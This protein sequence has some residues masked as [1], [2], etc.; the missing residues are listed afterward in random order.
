MLYG[1]AL[2][3]AVSAGAL[4]AWG[5]AARP[6]EVTVSAAASLTDVLREAAR[7]YELRT[8]DRVVLNL[9]ASNTLARQ[10]A[11]GGRVDVFI[12][13]DAAQMDLVA[14]HLVPGSRIDLLSN[15]LAIAVPDDR[16]IR[17]TSARDLARRDVARIATGDPAAVPAGVYAKAYLQQIGIW[18]AVRPKIVPA[19]S[20][21]L[22]LAAVEHGAADAAIVFRTDIA[23]ARRAREAFVVPA[24][25]GPRIVYPAAAVRGGANPEAARRFLAW[26][27]SP[28]ASA[29]FRRAGF[30]ALAP[31]RR[32]HR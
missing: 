18:D 11:A 19:G 21:R 26:L 8:G 29:L 6:P 24:G 9:A 5:S 25:E 10:I 7:L 16:P 30:I 4:G 17:F 22:A 27:E 3:L 1:A 2:A 23:T 12:S 15:Q 28:E 14:A 32:L 31:A 13:A 20:V